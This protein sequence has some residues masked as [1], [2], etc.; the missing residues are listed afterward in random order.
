MKIIEQVRVGTLQSDGTRPVIDEETDRT[1]GSVQCDAGPAHLGT[2]SVY[3][4]PDMD[5]VRFGGGQTYRLL[6]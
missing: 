2:G 3:A 1:I 5:V 6:W 4:L